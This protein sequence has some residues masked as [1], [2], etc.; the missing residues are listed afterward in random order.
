MNIKLAAYA[1]LEELYSNNASLTSGL[2]SLNPSAPF[3]QIQNAAQPDVVISHTYSRTRTSS[4]SDAKLGTLPVASE[5]LPS[6]PALPP[7][8]LNLMTLRA[9]AGT[10]TASTA[11]PSNGAKTGALPPPTMALPPLPPPLSWHSRN[12]DQNL[13]QPDYVELEQMRS[14]ARDNLEFNNSGTTDDDFNNRL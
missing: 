13:L 3:N 2:S 8:Q 9:A 10:K 11:N 6:P 12:A 5:R 1:S 14:E 4:N 7:K